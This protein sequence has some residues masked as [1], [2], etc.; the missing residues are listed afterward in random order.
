MSWLVCGLWFGVVAGM[1]FSVREIASTLRPIATARRGWIG[2]IVVVAAVSFF[3]G[4]HNY[5]H[6]NWPFARGYYADLRKAVGLAPPASVRRAQAAKRGQGEIQTLTLADGTREFVL[7]TMLHR[8]KARLFPHFPE[9]HIAPLAD[10]DGVFS[11]LHFTRDGAVS[12]S[13]LQMEKQELS[14][15]QLGIVKGVHRGTDIFK[16]PDTNKVYVSYVTIDTKTCVS[17]KLDEIVIQEPG[18]IEQ[19]PVFQTS[20]TLPPYGLNHGG[21]RIQQDSTGRM[22]LTVGDFWKSPLAADENSSFGKILVGKP[23][24]GFAIYSRGHRNPQ[25]LLWDADTQTLLETEHGPS[26]GDEI[27]IIR[28]NLHY[29]WPHETYGTNYGA[30]PEDVYLADVGVSYG[31]HD[32][33]TKPIFSYSP[34]I[35]IG[36]IRKVPA[37]SFEFPNWVGSYLIAGMAPRSLSLY[38]VVIVDNRVV[39]NEPIRLG[40]IRDFVVAPTGVIVASRVDGLLVVRRDR[41]KRG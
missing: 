30:D 32:R 37:D 17:L 23:G 34:G 39:E 13:L 31:R 3:A 10:E 35:G 38:R 26:G 12:L 4:A 18:P 6:Q 20:C 33:Y 5:R 24:E 1:R 16:A 25:G 41:G 2:A 21:G 7:G 15:R 27:N 28:E 9:G 29:G 11:F 36:Q 19:R 40:R 8:V 14:T 22:F